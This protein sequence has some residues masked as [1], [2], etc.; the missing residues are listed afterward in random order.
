M[1]KLTLN[2]LGGAIEITVTNN[3]DGVVIG[4]YQGKPISRHYESVFDNYLDVWANPLH[5]PR[6]DTYIYPVVRSLKKVAN[7]TD[8]VEVK[9][10][11]FDLMKTLSKNNNPFDRIKAIDFVYNHKDLL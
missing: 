10:E 3:K 2:N 7:G 5:N 6:F 9:Y 4:T 1:K 11:A 8:N